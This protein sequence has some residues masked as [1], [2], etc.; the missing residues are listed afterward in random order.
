MYLASKIM[1]LER[2]T[3]QSES[4]SPES[5]HNKEVP[6]TSLAGYLELIKEKPSTINHESLDNQ[7]GADDTNLFQ[8]EQI[9]EKQLIAKVEA[10]E[11]VYLGEMP[12]S[13]YVAM[14]KNGLS[15]ENVERLF[16][17][18]EQHNTIQNRIK[19]YVFIK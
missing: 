2:F 17:F 15:P 12:L 18:D 10:G 4:N 13:E 11:V 14:R 8:T 1:P 3:P 7:F 6:V 16:V 19:I 5:H 9:K